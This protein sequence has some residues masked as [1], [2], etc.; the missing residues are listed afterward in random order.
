M[1]RGLS[2]GHTNTPRSSR[3]GACE[4][5]RLWNISLLK[6]APHAY[7]LV[8]PADDGTP[9][10]LSLIRDWSPVAEDASES[11]WATGC[12][13]ESAV[14]IMEVPLGAAIESG[15]EMFRVHEGD[16]AADAFRALHV[17]TH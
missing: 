15:V 1:I 2:L 9:D 8:F 7:L 14:V 17:G 6:D 5:C 10:A 16:G 11:A 3:R 13:R 4:E 12:N